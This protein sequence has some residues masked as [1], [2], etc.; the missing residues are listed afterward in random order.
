LS[1]A[2]ETPNRYGVPEERYRHLSEFERALLPLPTY[3]R[4]FL[5]RAFAGE[6]YEA[7]AVSARLRSKRAVVNM[8]GRDDVRDVVVRF[9]PLIGDREHARRLLEPIAL[10]AIALNLQL[11]RGK[12]RR[13]PGAA[14]TAA[15]EI[16]SPVPLPRPLSR[17]VPGGAPSLPPSP[18]ASGGSQSPH[19]AAVAAR[20]ARR[21]AARAVATPERSRAL[22]DLEPV[23][24]AP[25]ETSAGPP[26][27]GAGGAMGGD[28]EGSGEA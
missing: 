11:P 12:D 6:S 2:P 18:G 22:L 10:R 8:L 27:D 3:C 7:A 25:G 16:L 20:E 24:V 28:A 13:S 19:A 5:R 1:N 9:A 26:A 14:T 4:R 21:A 17:T 15:K 23:D